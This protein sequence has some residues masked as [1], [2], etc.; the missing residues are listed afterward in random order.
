MVDISSL[1]I[2]LNAAYSQS[3]MHVGF[4]F[5]SGA[6]PFLFYSCL[7][8]IINS[9]YWNLIKFEVGESMIFFS[10]TEDISD[11]FLLQLIL[12]SCPDVGLSVNDKP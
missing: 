4:L 12:A 10:I 9:N 8:G 3:A 2:Y 11:E 6:A 7:P 1:I 5:F